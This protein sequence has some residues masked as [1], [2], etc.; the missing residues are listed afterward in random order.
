M[1]ANL[2]RFFGFGHGEPETRQ[3]MTGRVFIVTPQKFVPDPDEGD[4][5]PCPHVK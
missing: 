5:R 2:H 4:V 3:A 1:I